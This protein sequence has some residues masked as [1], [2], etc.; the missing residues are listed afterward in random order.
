VLAAAERHRFEPDAPVPVLCECDDDACREFVRATVAEVREA[1]TAERAIFA[2]GHGLRSE[3]A[4][5]RDAFH[6]VALPP[7]PD[8]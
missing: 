4:Q 1:H 8:A 6:D 7:S 5:R 3:A 2:P